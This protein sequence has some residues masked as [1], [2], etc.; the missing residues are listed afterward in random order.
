MKMARFTFSTMELTIRTSNESALLPLILIFLSNICRQMVHLVCD[1][2]VTDP[3]MSVVSSDPEKTST[4]V[5]Y[6]NAI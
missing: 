2:T 5:C 1:P 6:C 4:P 3:V